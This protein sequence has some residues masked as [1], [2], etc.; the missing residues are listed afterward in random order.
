MDNSRLSSVIRS[1]QLW[2][3]HNMSTHTSRRHETALSEHRLQRFAINSR[4]F[5]LLTSPMYSSDSRAVERAI[6][7][8]RDDFTVM[9]QFAFDSCALCPWDAGIGNEDVET[10]VEVADCG[11]DGR[12]YGVVGCYVYLVCFGCRR[13][14]RSVSYA[15]QS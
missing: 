1:L 9:V 5:L 8:R 13:W 4:L 6:Q 12:G 15:L 10:A 7:I 14:R 2:D 3:V 11:L